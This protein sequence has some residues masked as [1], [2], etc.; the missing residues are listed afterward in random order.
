MLRNQGYTLLQAT[1]VFWTVGELMRHGPTSIQAPILLV[2]IPGFALAM[3]VAN[4]RSVAE[5]LRRHRVAAPI[6]VVEEEAVL[7]PAPAPGP[8]NP[9]EADEAAGGAGST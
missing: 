1:N 5:E 4:M 6:R 7:H 8:S 2:A 9:W 3:L